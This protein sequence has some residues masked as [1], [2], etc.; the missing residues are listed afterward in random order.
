MYFYRKGALR[1]ETTGSCCQRALLQLLLC[2]YSSCDQN[3][4]CCFIQVTALQKVACHLLISVAC[5]LLP[6]CVC[7][8]NQYL[9]LQTTVLNSSIAHSSACFSHTQLLLLLLPLCSPRTP[10]TEALSSGES[11]PASLR[12]AALPHWQLQAQA[13]FSMGAHWNWADLKAGA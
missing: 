5:A 12:W 1:G 9:D 11:C 6:P 8:F 10:S 7:K 2:I 3:L 13:A 4:L